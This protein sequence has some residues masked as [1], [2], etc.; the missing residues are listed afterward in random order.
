MYSNFEYYV[1]TR[2]LF[3]KGVETQAGAAIRQAHGT[4]V[5]VHYSNS[6]KRSGLLERVEHSLR[7]AGLP[8]CLLDGVVPNPHLGTVYEGIRLGLS[9]QVDF[10]LA[11]GGGSAI[12]SAKAIACGIANPEEDVWSYYIRKGTT[13]KAIPVGCVPTIAAAGSEMSGGS[14]ITNEANGLK[15]DFGGDFMRPVFALMNPDLTLSVS[16]YQTS[17]GAAD[18]LMHTMERFFNRCENM[19]IT[20]AISIAILK[21][22]MSTARTLMTDPQNE[23]ARADLMWAGSLSHNDLTGCGTL[24]G[25]WATH[26]MEHELGGMFDVAHGAGLT[27]LWGSW[28][29]YVWASAPERFYQFAV[30]VMDV[31]NFGDVPLVVEQ[32]IV[33]MENF[34]HEIH[35]PICLRELGISPTEEQIAFMAASCEEK[36]GGQNGVVRPLKKEDMIRIYHMAMGSE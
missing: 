36:A 26:N 21:T 29:R 27:A 30:E 31:E 1:P 4:R 10:V 3:G 12:D 24:G 8:Y 33:A 23:K 25:D 18:I 35:M 22:V 32:G 34:F 20:D 28:A 19:A 5:L 16:M 7:D 17:S 14:V 11:I 9:E 13:T 6:A 15:R 2:V